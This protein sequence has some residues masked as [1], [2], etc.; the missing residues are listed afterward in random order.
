MARRLLALL[1]RLATPA[2]AAGLFLGLAAPPLARLLQP[3]LLPAVVVLLFL[4]L[5]RLD[6][7]LL[8]GHVRRPGLVLLVVGWQLLVSPLLAHA[9]GTAIP[10]VSIS[11]RR[12]ASAS[13]AT[14]AEPQ[15]MVQP[16]WPWPVL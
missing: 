12:S 14:R 4:S 10:A 8:A 3:L 6:W 16:M 15:A 13:I 5:L 2:L 11:G 7:S 9:A 1:G